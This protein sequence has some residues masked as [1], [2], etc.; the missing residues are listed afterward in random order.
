MLFIIY[1]V[2]LF[3]FGNSIAAISLSHAGMQNCIRAMSY[4]SLG[5]LQPSIT[6]LQLRAFVDSVF[7]HRLFYLSIL[8]QQ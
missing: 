5:L 7:E 6:S 3:G 4:Y 2:I 1:E 8:I